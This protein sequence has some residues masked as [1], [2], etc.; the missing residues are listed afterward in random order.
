METHCAQPATTSRTPGPKRLVTLVLGVLLAHVLVIEMMARLGQGPGV[1]DLMATPEFNH[2]L[3]LE[4]GTATGL[5]AAAS[6]VD[7][8]V[9]STVGQVVQARTLLP[10]AAPMP[11]AAA[12]ATPK[13]AKASAASTSTAPPPS[14]TPT[15]QLAFDTNAPPQLA[16][17]SAATNEPTVPLATTVSTAMANTP[18]AAGQ[19]PSSDAPAL[20]Q[21]QKDEQNLAKTLNSNGFSATENESNKAAWLAT[22]PVSTRLSY[23]LNGYFRGDFSGKARVQWQRH[24]DRYQAQVDVNVALLLNLRMTSQGR[25]TPTR[26][27]PE[28]YE[29]ERRGKKRSARLGDQLLHLDNGSSL[30][31]PALLQDTASQFVQLAQDFALG[32]QKLQ[33]GAVVPVMLARPGGVDEWIYDVVAL[34]TLRTG[35]GEVAA[36]HLKPRPLANPRGNITVDMWFAPRLQHLPARIRLTLNEDTWLDLMLDAIEQSTPHS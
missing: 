6:V 1:L 36:Y 33:V 2:A 9:Q 13:T 8:P 15:P 11:L 35:L 5:S 34:D 21:A 24:A 12:L 19:S 27:W 31:R 17:V 7:M 4:H 29:E 10:P 18:P 20:V 32:R 25:I 3:K 28:T 26:L 16:P 30:P 23:T 14:K 22:W